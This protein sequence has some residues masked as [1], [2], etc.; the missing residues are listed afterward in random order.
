V[1]THKFSGG[2]DMQ[3]SGAV[4]TPNAEIDFGGN[5]DANSEALKLMLIA[6]TL[7]IRGNPTFAGLDDSQMP[8]SLLIP[9]IVE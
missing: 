7:L 8:V 4:Y 2:A 5:F 1:G 6:D 3:L 9:R